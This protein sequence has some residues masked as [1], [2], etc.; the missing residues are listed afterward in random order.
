MY[1]YDACWNFQLYKYKKIEYIM[2]STTFFYSQSPSR[3]TVI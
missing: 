2:E 1:I 3:I